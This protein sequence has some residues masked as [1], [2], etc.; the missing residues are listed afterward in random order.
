[1]VEL[2]YRLRGCDCDRYNCGARWKIKGVMRIGTDRCEIVGVEGISLREQ[3]FWRRN[4]VV[5]EC[6]NASI[7]R[8][9]RVV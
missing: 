1:M 2:A 4:D 7:V 5:V 6:A 9:Y 8:V 3:S